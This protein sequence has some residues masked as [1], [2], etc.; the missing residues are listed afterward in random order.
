MWPKTD[1]RSQFVRE[2]F[3][4]FWS[5]ETGNH[6]ENTTGQELWGFYFIMEYVSVSRGQICQQFAKTYFLSWVVKMIDAATPGN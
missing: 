4:K 6:Q 3:A 5:L 2:G 1:H